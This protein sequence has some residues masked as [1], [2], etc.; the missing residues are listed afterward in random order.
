MPHLKGDLCL[1]IC[2]FQNGSA[3]V[4]RDCGHRL[5]CVPG[6]PSFLQNPDNLVY[7]TLC[8]LNQEA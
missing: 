6:F 1:S 7:L 4:T 2:I 3:R 8:I 5:Q